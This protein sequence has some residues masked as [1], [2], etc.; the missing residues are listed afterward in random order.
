MFQICPVSLLVSSLLMLI[1]GDCT[2]LV[3]FPLGFTQWETVANIYIHIYVC[4]YIYIYIHGWLREPSRYFLSLFS[5]LEVVDCSSWRLWLLSGSPV[6]WRWI[7]ESFG[8]SCPSS[9]LQARNDNGPASLL[10]SGCFSIPIS[11]PYL[12]K[13]SLQHNLLNPPLG[14]LSPASYLMDIDTKWGLNTWRLTTVLNVKKEYY[15]TLF[16]QNNL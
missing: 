13:W 16:P 11:L 4:T 12:C 2:T 15:E 3:P 14:V 5:L 8:N 9:L 6:L 10:V 1:S 7:S